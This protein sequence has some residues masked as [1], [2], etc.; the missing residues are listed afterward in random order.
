[1]G[2]FL[3]ALLG[4]FAYAPPAWIERV[5]RR[6]IAWTVGGVGLGAALVGGGYYAYQQLPK[7]LR[8]G[9][10]VE[11]PGI[12]PI[13]DDELKPM[14]LRLLFDY[15]PNPD[16]QQP[17]PLS[18]ARLDLAGNIVET[19]IDMQ[20]A[21]PGRWR[22]ETDN[23]LVFEP[24]EDWARR[25]HFCRAARSRPIRGQCDVGER[26]GDVRDAGIRRH[27]GFR[28]VLPTPAAGRRTPRRRR[29]A[30]HACGRARRVGEAPCADDVAGG[31]RKRARIPHRIRCPRSQRPPALGVSANPRTLLLRHSRGRRGRCAGRARRRRP[32]RSVAGAGAG[33]G[34]HQLFPRR[35]GAGPAG[36]R[37]R[38]ARRANR[39]VHLHRPS[40]YRRLRRAGRRLAAAGR[41]R[42][43]R[44]DVSRPPVAVAARSIG[45][46]SCR[47]RTTARGREPYR[48]RHGGDAKH[49][50]GCAG[51]PLRLPAHRR[52][53]GIRR[54]L[55]DGVSPTM[56]SCARR[57]TARKRPSHRM[58]RCCRL[59]VHVG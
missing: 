58:A 50:F 57:D 47:C 13:V 23:H 28:D 54:R 56:P 7:P 18:A 1:M 36:R 5:G 27:S 14:P 22:F 37:R 3:K 24:S 16:V 49:H 21:M 59:P 15:L 31:R 38:G 20:P 17:A 33:A 41:S 29:P 8:V 39:G 19:G 35:R 51:R 6:R 55:S 10:Q 25:A 30:L 42:R 48:T 46:D 45:A 9:V 34:S 43:P 40:A 53:L 11:A 26:T 12:T 32:R 2:T 4:T 52:R 44:H